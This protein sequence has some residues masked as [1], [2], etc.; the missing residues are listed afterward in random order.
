LALWEPLARDGV[1]RAQNNIGA[2]FSE[3]LGVERDPALVREMAVAGGRWRRCGRAA[4]LATAYFK[5]VG[6][7]SDGVRAAELSSRRRGTGRRSAQD[8]LSWILLE[9]DVIRRRRRGASLGAGSCRER[10]R[11]RHD[12]AGHALSQR[13]SG[14]ERD[15]AVAA[16]WW[17]PRRRVGRCRRAGDA[18]AP[19]TISAAASPSNRVTRCLALRGQAG[20]GTLAAPSSDRFARADAR[21]DCEAGRRAQLAD[22]P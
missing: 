9:G 14:V 21:G 11:R 15:A 19:R 6:V 2:C 13:Q 4:Q 1:A 10:R 3:G 5:G 22:A 8:M 20:A 17:R 18:P 7:E 12:P 16:D